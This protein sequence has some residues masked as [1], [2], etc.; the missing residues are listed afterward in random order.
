MKPNP[1]GHGGVEP[2]PS[3]EARPAQVSVAVTLEKAK[4]HFS[5]L[6]ASVDNPRNPITED[7]VALGR[8]L[9]FDKRLSKNHDL[10]CASCH[11]LAN[12]GIDIRE[13]NGARTKTSAGHGGQMGDRNS[14]T[15][16][17][18]GLH[19][20]Q[21]WDGRSRDLE[22]QAKGPVTNPVE[23]AMVDEASVV[24]TLASIPGYV[25]A[26]GKAFPGQPNA[27]SYDNM[28]NAIGAFERRLMTPG[29]FDEFLGGKLT[30]L[31]EAQ[32]RGLALFMDT[33][34]IQCHVG[35]GLGGT[36]YKKLGAT[37]DWPGL[38]DEGRAK[39]TR[40]PNDKFMFKVPSLR[41]VTETGPYLHD[42]SI[43]SLEEMVA[44]MAEYQLAKDEV[45]PDELA[46]LVAF[47]GS[48]K[49]TLPT[50]YIAEPTLPADG[51]ETPAP[52]PA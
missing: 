9:Y 19:I 24:A 31:D 38:K 32:L 37:K 28:A 5:K 33:G 26:F 29:P 51:P 42:G 17:N 30:A 12:Y 35:P 50:E 48:L 23:M 36:E 49:G 4:V 45:P 11:D 47:L 25:E 40:G 6:P 46:A 27:V 39:V 15:V 34:C 13:K 3:I 16:Y 21:F 44:K 52:N 7:K 18:A 14:P 10:S 8:M 41:N 43:D 22:D 2:L 1:G 20:A